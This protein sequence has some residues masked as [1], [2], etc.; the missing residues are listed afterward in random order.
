MGQKLRV[1]QLTPSLWS[2]GVEERMAR[3]LSALDRNRFE[4]SWIGFGPIR[5][6]LIERAG[7]D[8]HVTAIPRNPAG[9]I[10]PSI[11]TRLVW[12]LRRLRPDVMHVHNWSTG[13]YGIVAATVSGVNAVIYESAGRESPTAP[14]PR[15]QALMHALAPHVTCFTT[16][17]EF[18]GKE[19]EE[20]W[21]ARPETIRVM[22][23]GVDLERIASAPNR[24]AARRTLGIP[25]DAFVIGALSVLRPV[26]RIPDLIAAVGKLASRNPKIHLVVAG[27]AL[28]MSPESLRERARE[29]GLEDRFHMPG[30]IEDPPSILKAFD[31]F[32][33]CSIFEGASNAIIEA[34]ASGVSVVATRVGG[35]PELLSDG[36]HGLLVPPKD[37]DALAVALER[38]MTDEALR[39]RCIANALS[40]AHRRHSFE[41]MVQAYSDLFIELG[42]ERL[43]KHRVQKSLHAVRAF[44]EGFIN[45]AQSE[46]LAVPEL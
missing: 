38:M 27:N 9:G 28:R 30:R 22:P 2:G 23:T 3:I 7:P 16:V 41:H 25:E 24:Q 6:A 20:Y 10:E 36:I 34:M 5:E 42:E 21:G 43:S 8:I 12:Q 37:V 39:A 4:L 40:R 17:C 35:T 46:E 26:K 45:A 14:L 44:T 11:I 29:L 32:V 1:C 33:N 13:F 19:N 15:R 18:L 31:V